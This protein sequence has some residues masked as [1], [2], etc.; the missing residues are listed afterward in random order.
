MSALKLQHT[1][2]DI[3]E[4]MR[5]LAPYRP[6]VLFNEFLVEGYSAVTLSSVSDTRALELLR[7]KL[8]LGTLITLYDDYADRPTQCDPDLLEM[9]YRLDFEGGDSLSDL[10]PM[11]RRVLL[12]AKSLLAATADILRGLPH[13]AHF[14]E[15]LR[16]DLRQFYLANQYSSLLLANSDLGSTIENRLYVHHNM[17]MVLVAMMDLMATERIQFSELG[18][19]REV[20]LMGQ[21]MGRIFNVLTTRKREVA[22]GDITGELATCSTEEEILWAESRLRR[23]LKCLRR[24][25]LT[26]DRKIKTFSVAGYLEGLMK[27]QRLHERM[28][29]II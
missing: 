1:L 15:V 21:R 13:Y 3:H 8:C 14:K 20:F 17:G 12:F 2:R 19:M 5:E 27:V 16:F 29:G 25:I 9:L 4:N 28:E 22:D 6:A 18:L 10:A 24:Q 23:E 26:Y 7:A 11:N